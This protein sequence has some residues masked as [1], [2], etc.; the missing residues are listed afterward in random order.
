MLLPSTADIQK[1]LGPSRELKTA[2]ISACVN[3]TGVFH[4]KSPHTTIKSC[5]T[6]ESLAYTEQAESVLM[7][8]I[9]FPLMPR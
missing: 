7:S 5:L 3:Y 1:P 8:H 9:L 2:L 4:F 6:R